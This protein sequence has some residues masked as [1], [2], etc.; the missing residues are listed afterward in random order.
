MLR[1]M[2]P[3]LCL[4][5]TWLAASAALLVM[6]TAQHGFSAEAP[7]RTPAPRY[8]EL[9]A[10]PA[11]SYV[12]RVAANPNTT[13]GPSLSAPSTP[14]P[15][16]TTTWD[17]IKESLSQSVGSG[18]YA[19]ETLA[20]P[21]PSMPDVPAG[22]HVIPFA[23]P[24]PEAKVVLEDHDGLVTL[25]VRD[26]S[27]R[28]VIAMIAERQNL[29]IV[30]AAPADIAITASLDKVPWQHAFDSL[31]SASGYTWTNYDGIIFIS[32]LE[33]A[34]FM[35]PGAG[36]RQTRVF[37]LDFASAV[38]VDQAAKGL[39]SPGGQSWILESSSSDNRRSREA[40]VVFDYLAHLQRI[41]NY[42]CQIDVAPRQVLIE[43][44]VLQ[45]GLSDDSR[46][47]VNFESIASFNGNELNFNTVGLANATSPSAF[48]LTV[49]GKALDGLVELL[50]TTADAKSLASPRLLVVNGQEARIQIGERL[51]YRVT[52]TTQTSSMESVQFLEVGVVL[53]VTP[54]IT[55]DG[56]VMMRIKPKVSKGEI[57]IET[58]L[59]EEE[60]T[61]VETDILLNDGQGMVIGGLI[62]E[63]D[64]IVQSKVPWL[65]DLPYVGLLFQ[66]RQAVKERS[67]LIVTLVPHIQP[68]TPCVACREAE[69]VMRST[70]PITTGPLCTAPRPYEPR[71]YD[72]LTNP[73]R[74]LIKKQCNVTPLPRNNP[75][76]PMNYP[77]LVPLPPVEEEP[78]SPLWQGD[79][80]PEVLAPPVEQVHY[81][82]PVQPQ[83]R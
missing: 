17:V 49:T 44:N 73:R 81:V 72:A 70:Q 58:E 74:V 43:A 75:N 65:G 20:L 79:L 37:E 18:S 68:Y 7:T 21:Q 25:I 31:L 40:V 80:G 52:T 78:C 61:E 71:L 82:T 66:R 50:K 36:G 38:D 11:T 30:F 59:P 6:L 23:K 62:Q 76:N 13:T 28:Q 64:S 54:R 47:G 69:E 29:N 55:R 34:N 15:T 1:R 48:F 24:D 27:L 2:R 22:Q 12:P 4:K 8:S 42:V 19:P 14:A 77:K 45:V 16:T 32:S 5:A 83:V 41:E 63:K 39:L 51:S 26:G 57:N 3:Y 33:T 10:S 35:P 46:N 60:T 9:P 53:S 56:R 67:E